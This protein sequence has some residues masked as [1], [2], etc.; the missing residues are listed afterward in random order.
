MKSIYLISA[1]LIILTSACKT[2]RDGFKNHESGLKYKFIEKN[3]GMPLPQIDE[4]LILDFTYTDS[5]GNIKYTSIGSNR[6][7]LRKLEEPS[8]PGGSIED[9]LAMMHVGDSAVFKI[10]AANFLRFS[11]EVENLSDGFDMKENYIFHIRLREIVKHDDFDSHLVAKYHESEEVE[12]ELLDKYLKRTSTRV[13][14]D[15]K[16]IYYIE[17]EAGQGEYIKVGNVVEIYYT[18]KLIDGRVFDTNLGKQPLQ[19]RVG[20]GGVIP[21]LDLGIRKMKNK[22]SGTLIIPSRHAYGQRGTAGILPYSTLIF[23][24]EVVNVH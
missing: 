5:D 1:I 24:I 8:H 9:A 23:E 14:P 21:G 2:D 20:D 18:G 19:F 4:V 16:G 10:N 22:T 11:E 6:D 13:E 12:M 3:P 7:Y 15:E 17:Q